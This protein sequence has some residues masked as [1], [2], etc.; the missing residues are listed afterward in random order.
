MLLQQGPDPAAHSQCPGTGVLRVLM[1]LLS[2]EKNPYQTS[3]LIIFMRKQK[4]IE[5]NFNLIP[6]YEGGKKVK[7]SI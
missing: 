7:K 5:F 4:E 3:S 1:E 6:D 2:E